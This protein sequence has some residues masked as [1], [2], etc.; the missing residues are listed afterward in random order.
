M[1]G[2]SFSA[3]TSTGM[4]PPPT[5]EVTCLRQPVRRIASLSM[6]ISGTPSHLRR[7]SPL[8][9]RRLRG[10]GEASG[11]ANRIAPALR[12]VMSTHS[13]PGKAVS[14]ALSSASI[15]ARSAWVKALGS[16]GLCSSV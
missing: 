6:S 7:T 14:K 9:R 12:S 16:R 5:T 4:L 15:S 2:I 8:I 10:S 13:R 11:A 3:R 1:A